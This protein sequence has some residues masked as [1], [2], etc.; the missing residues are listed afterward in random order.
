MDWNKGILILAQCVVVCVLGAL[1]A[2]GK[3]SAITDGLLAV[4][5]SLVGISLVSTVAKKSKP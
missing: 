4:V 5:G 2:V 1:V 3:D